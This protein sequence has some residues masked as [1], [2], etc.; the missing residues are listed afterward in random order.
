MIQTRFLSSNPYKIAEVEAIL[1][2][3]GV[4]VVPSQVKIDEIQTDDVQKLVR[5]KVLKAFAKIGRPVFVE[6][7]GLH[8]SALN[9]LPGGLT[10]VFW[11]ALRADAFVNLV[12]NLANRDVTARTVIGFCD[13]RRV[14]LFEGEVKGTVPDAPSGPRDFQWD[15]TF[16]PAG[17]TSTFADMGAVKNTISM[18]RNALDK[19]AEYLR[20]GT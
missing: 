11:D 18:R 3:L 6:H 19:F 8:L 15:C 10:Q 9:G 7:T 4:M 2:P 5:D 1:A 17:H 12:K 16:V 13:G 20:P 14:H